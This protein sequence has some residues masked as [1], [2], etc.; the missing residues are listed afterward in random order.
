MRRSRTLL[1]PAVAASLAVAVLLAVAGPASAKLQGAHGASRATKTHNASTKVKVGNYG[2]SCTGVSG[3]LTFNPPL[4][5]NAS[6]KK[7]KVKTSASLSHCASV[8][9][10][11]GTPVAITSGTLS[12]TLTIKP[13]S[14]GITCTGV[15]AGLANGG[16]SILLTGKLSAKWVS[17]SKLSPSKTAIAVKS[18]AA[19]TSG[20][21]H[22]RQ[23]YLIPGHQ[24]STISGA[25]TGANSA[26]S[27][28]AL[29]SGL[30]PEQEGVQCVP[31]IS[32]GNGLAT[33]PLSGGLLD[34]GVSPSSIA[35][36]PAN[37][38]VSFSQCYTAVGTFP[39]GTSDLSALASWA[40]G[41]TAIATV[42]NS[43]INDG[44]CVFVRG[45]ANGTTTIAASFKATTGST[46]ITVSLPVTITTSSLPDGTVGTPYD[47][48][49][50]AANGTTPYSWS[51]SFGSLPSWASLNSAT[52]EITGT[53]D[54]TGT[55]SFTVQVTDSSTPTPQTDSQSLSITVN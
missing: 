30:T 41:N 55:T 42:D 1:I 48:T 43:G 36:T 37:A 38:T 16:G 14:S 35:V 15:L 51:I 40:I 27:L 54:A 46:G 34:S 9:T 21:S 32:G 25:F 4:T 29:V 24:A 19:P 39:G 50:A 17:S 45:H 22:V 44:G 26:G 8:P 49:L 11:G 52:G 31:S 10:A 13:T 47:Q 6:F 33:L 28:L 5:Q 23:T 12:G 20:N 2:L 3:S 18:A 7:E 53:P